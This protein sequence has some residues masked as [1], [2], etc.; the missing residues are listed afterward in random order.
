MCAFNLNWEGAPLSQ[1]ELTIALKEKGIIDPIVFSQN[2]GPLRMEY[3]RHGI[4]VVV[5]RHPLSD[6]LTLIEY[7][8]AISEFSQRIVEHRA[9]VVYGNTLQT[10][11]AIDAADRLTVPSVWNIRESEPWETYYSYLGDDLATRALSCYQK[12][13]RVIFVSNATRSGSQALNTVNNFAVIPNGLNLT[14]LK[15]S[16]SGMSRP[17]AR[18]LLDIGD[19]EVSVLL[20]GT[21]CERKG[22]K[23]LVRAAELL[24]HKNISR[25][26]VF[27][28]GD[29]SSTYSRELHDLIEALPMDVRSK[30]TIIPE[31]N[32]VSP[33]WMAAD[34]F[35][36]T[37]RVESYPRVILEAMAFGLPIVT[38][39]VYGISEQVRPG[40]NAFIYN[41]GDIES[42]ARCLEK[43]IEDDIVRKGF[44]EASP[45]VL[46]CLAS[47]ED[48][49]EAYGRTFA[50]AREVRPA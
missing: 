26:R 46:S 21:V 25:F 2:D 45:L 18:S 17:D 47:F 37:S 22:Q 39:S 30:I 48:M 4:P 34:I 9:E 3:E 24:N 40:K 15:E 14:R 31:T 27:I 19:N 50:E 11:Y 23:D 33:Y 36:C 35:V 13:Y 16:C 42:L 20:L 32:Y 8:D 49:V 7:E 43:L 29:R 44:A 6:G 10:F 12:P 41:P 38:T 1:F 28:V 5:D